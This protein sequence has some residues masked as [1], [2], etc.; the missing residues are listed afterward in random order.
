MILR[1]IFLSLYKDCLIRKPDSLA[2]LQELSR[3]QKEWLI[4]PHLDQ[5]YNYFP[6]QNRWGKEER[7][8]RLMLNS[9]FHMLIHTRPMAWVKHF[10]CMYPFVNNRFMWGFFHWHN[11]YFYS[12]P[13]VGE[14][15]HK[16]KGQMAKG[17]YQTSKICP[18]SLRNGYKISQT[19]NFYPSPR[20][21]WENCTIRIPLCGVTQD[22]GRR[23]LDRR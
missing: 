18:R 8:Q 16:Y 12:E 14:A 20:L 7:S 2:G 19:D 9:S 21:P 4:F 3:R 13:T 17:R 6:S 10:T 5:S 11:H 23:R 1:K 22:N 15:F